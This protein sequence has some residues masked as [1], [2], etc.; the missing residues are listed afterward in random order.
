M[1]SYSIWKSG[2]FATVLHFPHFSSRSPSLL[3]FS[4]ISEIIFHIERSFYHLTL[5]SSI[6]C[7]QFSKCPH[8][9][10]P[11]V[12]VCQFSVASLPRT[13]AKRSISFHSF[14]QLWK[15]GTTLGREKIRISTIHKRTHKC[16]SVY[17]KALLQLIN[18]RVERQIDL[19]RVSF[20]LGVMFI[21]A[22]PVLHMHINERIAFL[23]AN[24]SEKR[25]QKKRNDEW[26]PHSWKKGKSDGKTHLEIYA[27]R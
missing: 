25:N 22:R 21:C 24:A 8:T 11:L 9:H 1:K 3:G 2:G 6:E 13:N 17:L 7:H 4:P 19:F 5:F 18:D 27:Q 16:Y 15:N 14:G 10:L 26:A 12:R 20:R 23:Y